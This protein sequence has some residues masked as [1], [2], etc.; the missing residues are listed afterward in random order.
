MDNFKIDSHKLIYHI[1]RLFQWQKGGDIYPIYVE[2]GLSGACNHRCIFCAFDFLKYKPDFLNSSSL[3]T[4]IH[5]AAR[6]K[7]KSILY[8]GEGEPLLHK[9]IVEIIAFTKR[10]GI[11]V[12]LSTNGVMFD[13]EKATEILP[14]LTWI[15]VSLNAG[16]KEGYAYIHGTKSSDFDLVIKNLKRAVRIK[17]GNKNFCTIEVQFLLIPQNSKELLRLASILSGTGVDYLAV[18][19]YSQHPSSENR[20]APLF[21]YKDL[22]FLEEKLKKYSKDSFQVI[23]RKEAMKK[24]DEK[25]KPYQCCLGLPFIAHI[26]ADGYVYPC[27]AFAGKKSFS[28]GNICNDSFE[29]I[30]KGKR[31]KKIMSRIYNKWDVNKCRKSCRI[32]EINR[33]L[34]ELKNPQP[35]VN[36][37]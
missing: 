22:L 34:W 32:D 21:K 30:W 2:I 14:H 11:D 20:L 23:F 8:S 25:K 9:D 3:K 19:P 16:S 12:A 18:K 15:R 31:R 27:N 33:Y 10:K 37:I 17:K 6:K 1:P 35:H 5:Q 36:F 28:F 29:E 26:S 4:F 24:I 13:E 7:V